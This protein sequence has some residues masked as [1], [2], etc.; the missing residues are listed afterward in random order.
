[1]GIKIRKIGYMSRKN[2]VW[3]PGATYHVMS[4]GNRKTVLY[5]DTS[6]YLRF[7]ECIVMAKE[8]F[9]FKIHS[10]CLMTNHFHMSVETHDKELWKIMQKILHPYSMDFNHRYNFTGH[11]FESRYNACLI[12]DDR[13]FLEVSRYIHLNPVKAMMVREPL[14]YEYSSYGMF[15]NGDGMKAKNKTEMMISDLVDTSRVLSCFKYEPKEQYR[16]FVEGKISHAEQ[17]MLIQKD[18]REDDMW[19]P[20]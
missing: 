9:G 15:V 16:M 8:Q 18:I 7:L 14:A 13:Y 10:I 11:L 12:E 2:R 1:M 5:K 19:L 20:W 17:E 4:R 6:D 3:Y